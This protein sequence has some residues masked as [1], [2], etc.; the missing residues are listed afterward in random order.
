M[1]YVYQL[2]AFVFLF[3]F[4]ACGNPAQDT[5]VQK[6]EVNMEETRGV[7]V[8]TSTDNAEDFV[9]GG[10]TTVVKDENAE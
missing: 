10:D 8:N 2:G 4:I 3:F 7:D 1:K 5:E 9:G 6:E